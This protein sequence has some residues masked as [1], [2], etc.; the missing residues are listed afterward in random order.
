MSFD[1]SNATT[2]IEEFHKEELEKRKKVLERLNSLSNQELR[3]IEKNIFYSKNNKTFVILYSLNITKKILR[4]LKIIIRNFR[5][6]FIEENS[7]NNNNQV[8][9]EES[10]QYP[11][12]RLN[13]ED[14][15]YI[16]EEVKNNSNNSSIFKIENVNSYNFVFID[17]YS[18]EFSL[19]VSKS[20]LSFSNILYTEQYKFSIYKQVKLKNNNILNNFVDNLTKSNLEKIYHKFALNKISLVSEFIYEDEKNIIKKIILFKDLVLKLCVKYGSNNKGVKHNIGVN[21]KYNN[22]EVQINCSDYR[23]IKEIVLDIENEDNILSKEEFISKLSN[24]GFLNTVGKELSFSKNKVYKNLLYILKKL[25]LVK[26]INNSNIEILKGLLYENSY[27]IEKYSDLVNLYEQTKKSDLTDSYLANAIINSTASLVFPY[28][29]FIGN[30]RLLSNNIINICGVLDSENNNKFT[31]ITPKDSLLKQRSFNFSKYNYYR[32]LDINR[33]FN[34][35][36]SLSQVV[37]SNYKTIDFSYYEILKLL[38]HRGLLKEDYELVFKEYNNIE[39]IENYKI[40]SYIKIFNC[41]R[42]TLMINA[43]KNIRL[44]SEIDLERNIRLLTYNTNFESIRD[45]IN[46]VINS[47]LKVLKENLKEIEF[48]NIN[49]KK[50]L[51]SKFIPNV[52]SFFDFIHFVMAA[53]SYKS[54]D[55]LLKKDYIMITTNQLNKIIKYYN[56]FINNISGIEDDVNDLIQYTEKLPFNVKQKLIGEF[57]KLISLNQT[58]SR[59]NRAVKKKSSYRPITIV[60]TTNDLFQNVNPIVA[61]LLANRLDKTKI[62]DI[63]FKIQEISLNNM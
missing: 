13:N 23:I 60:E 28:I 61:I 27:D 45:N 7:E 58:H 37:G 12:D 32:D 62:K 52:N 16:F 56:N 1:L 20:C 54:D 43:H 38:V 49:F 19:I 57:N 14:Y 5:L 11:N 29:N 10:I 50:D 17:I 15:K 26:Y 34:W 22:C 51:I 33:S 31:I 25:D 4:N 36:L 39:Y 2:K 63:S 53:Y 40:S 6:D 41:N 30:D 48:Y 24:G 18:K 42:S 55:I 3:K 8:K 9:L 46:K 44:L 59:F 21:S 47:N 35:L